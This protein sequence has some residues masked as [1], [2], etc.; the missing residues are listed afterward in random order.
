MTPL[1]LAFLWMIAANVIA[2]IPSRRNHWPQA[3]A[4][5]AAGLPILIWV[6]A[7]NGLAVGLLVLAAGA[8]VLRWPLRFAWA[9]L[10][11]AAGRRRRG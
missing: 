5:I 10:T 7:E 1:I 6:T 11:R 2:M 9:W 8:S 3:W 4:L